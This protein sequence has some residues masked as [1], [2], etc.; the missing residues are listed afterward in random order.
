MKGTYEMIKQKDP[1]YDTKY[2][3]GNTLKDQFIGALIFE[4]KIQIW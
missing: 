2:N 3:Y 1:K 4:I